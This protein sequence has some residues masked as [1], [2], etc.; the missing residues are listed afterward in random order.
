MDASESPQPFATSSVPTPR[1]SFFRNLGDHLGFVS[2]PLSAGWMLAWLAA[3]L[4][5]T[6][7]VALLAITLS[8]GVPSIVIAAA[9]TFLPRGPRNDAQVETARIASDLIARSGP[10]A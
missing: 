6:N 10:D 7:P 9:Q 4:G 2:A 1:R 3:G 8:V 5:A